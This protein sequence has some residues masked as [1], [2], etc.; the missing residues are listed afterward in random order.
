[1]IAAGCAGNTKT[2]NRDTHG[3]LYEINAGNGPQMAGGS[4]YGGGD[5]AVGGHAPG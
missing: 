4:G 2:Q 3:A 5:D 1:M